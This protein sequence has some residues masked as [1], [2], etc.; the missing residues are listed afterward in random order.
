MPQPAPG[1]DPIETD[2]TTVEMAFRSIPLLILFGTGL[3]AAIVVLNNVCAP[4]TNQAFV[5]HIM[6]MDT[7]NQDPGTQW[8]EIRSPV[9]H[10]IA[11]YSILAVEAAVTVLCLVGSYMLLTNLGAG[12]E[13][14]EAAKLYGYLGF[15]GALVV[16]FL[17]IQVVGAQ[18]FVSWQS[19]DWNAI[20]DS[21]RINLITLAGIILLR[22]A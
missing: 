20:R 10:R 8:R 6:T 13:A 1:G 14:W 3:M 12:A 19:K 11:F 21:T 15:A 7:T 4:R 22:L 9:L 17:I 2:P 16:W 5:R 18:W